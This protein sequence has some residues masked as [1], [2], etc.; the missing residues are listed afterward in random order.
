MDEFTPCI[1]ESPF[2]ASEN[3][4]EEQHSDYLRQCIR[5]CVEN[6]YTPYAS[7]RMLTDAFDDSIPEEREL[8]I[9]A[10]FAMNKCIDTVLVF[11]DLGLSKGMLRGIATH[12]E[13]GKTV[14]LKSIL[15]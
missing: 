3:Y 1:I 6:G 15:P 13:A 10:G 12:G 7:H 14:M 4:S 11:G 5:W 8:G 2:K 9:Q